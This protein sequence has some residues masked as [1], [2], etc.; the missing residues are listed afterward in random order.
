MKGRR[1]PANEPG[2]KLSDISF[3]GMVH[4]VTIRSPEPSGTMVGIDLPDLPR[5]YFSITAADIPGARYLPFGNAGIPV[6]A[7]GRVSYAG[8]PVALL[9]GQD[10]SVL[11]SLLA[12]STVRI[13][14]TPWHADLESFS[15]ERVAS[16]RILERGDIDL[17]FSVASAIVEGEYRVGAQD[18]LYSEPQGAFCQFEYDKLLVRCATQW[19]SN[20]REAVSAVLG[21]GATEIIVRPT[22][23]GEHLDGKLWYPSL[24]ACHAALAAMKCRKPA[25]ILLTRGEDFAF[26]PKRARALIRHR[27]ALDPAGSLSAMD[28]RITLDTGAYAPLADELLA[29]ACVDACG[30]YDVPNVRIE[31]FA[32][33]TNLPPLGA[34]AGLGSSQSFFAVETHVDKVARSL[35][36]DPRTWRADAPKRRI[37][38]GRSRPLKPETDPFAAIALKLSETSDYAR[39]YASYHLLAKRGA[40]PV[41]GPSRGIGFAYVHQ[42]SGAFLT[43]SGN[44]EYRVEAVLDEDQRLTLRTGSVTGNKGTHDIWRATAAG[45]LGIPAAPI[46]IDAEDSVDAS[47]SGPS[48][49]SSNIAIINKLVAN[50]CTTIRRKRSSNTPPHAASSMYRSL[51]PVPEPTYPVELPYDDLAFGGAVVEVE[52]DPWSFETRILGVWLC[53]DGGLIVSELQAR[54]AME[55]GVINA[56]SQS[57]Y[58]QLDFPDGVP[59]TC[60][61]DHPMI[62][63][64]E[65]PP[66]ETHFIDSGVR[67]AAKG[68]GEIPFSCVPSA[69]VQAI[70]QASGIGCW[71]LPVSIDELCMR[72]AGP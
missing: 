31:G 53:V 29:R 1:S 26:S 24:L 13:E 60:L 52:M 37:R 57:L 39:K 42:G 40:Q 65:I 25:L 32:V 3:E 22:A 66:I 23:L 61:V 12:R 36:A 9:A 70:S 27:S 19:P 71:T 50:A 54:R 18:H 33:R 21:A 56:L 35:G 7:E 5:G 48:I 59:S 46:V 47:G 51:R 63:L 72:A 41:E 62:R 45:I 8:E 20:V 43:K 17:A 28:V 44:F 11:E 55:T 58:E 14:K 2:L 64:S 67:V 30:A 34:F 4:V 69:L 15:S 49:F 38:P 16:R 6:F 10:E 68:I